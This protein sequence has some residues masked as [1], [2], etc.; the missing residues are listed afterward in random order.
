M[1][2]PPTLRRVGLVACSKSKRT[3][4]AL[5][6]DLYQG[7]LFRLARQVAERDC[8]QWGILSAEHGLVLPGQVLAPYEKTLQHMR[9]QERRDWADATYADLVEHFGRNVL[10]VAYAGQLYR[11]ALLGLT[12]EA[13]LAGL[14]IGRQIQALQRMLREQA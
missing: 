2:A 12:F 7:H 9:A 4:A 5:A 10:Y 8:D 13:P 6:Q 14:G 11:E 3:E 1:M